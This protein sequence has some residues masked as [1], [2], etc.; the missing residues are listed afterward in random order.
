MLNQVQFFSHAG[1]PVQRNFEYVSYA[2]AV[3]RVRIS[4]Y[5]SLPSPTHTLIVSPSSGISR[6]SLRFSIKPFSLPQKG[7]LSA[8]GRG[9]RCKKTNENGRRSICQV[10][11]M[12]WLQSGVDASNH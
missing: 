12:K 11:F 4:T 5:K 3:I 9:G 10:A 8:R 2:D 6:L 7:C 1:A